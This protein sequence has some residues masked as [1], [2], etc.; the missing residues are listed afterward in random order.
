MQNYNNIFVFVHSDFV[1]VLT[2][3]IVL[4]I[5]QLPSVTFDANSFT[6]S[7]QPNIR[8][9]GSGDFTIQ[10]N[11]DLSVGLEVQAKKLIAERKYSDAIEILQKLNLN[12]PKKSVYFA[13]KIRFLEKIVENAK[14]NN[15]K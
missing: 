11:T 5:I 15:L 4:L 1:S 13:D 9:V 14:K 12:N 6:Q 8:I 3:W 10:T 7:I 2:A